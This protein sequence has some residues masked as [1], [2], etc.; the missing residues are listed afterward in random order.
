VRK[1]PFDAGNTS[2]TFQIFVKPTS[3]NTV[4]LDVNSFDTVRSVIAKTQTKGGMFQF[5]TYNV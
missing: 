5:L 1:S 4:V 2:K 3:G